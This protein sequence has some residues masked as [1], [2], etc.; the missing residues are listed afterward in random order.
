MNIHK[1]KIVR[2]QVRQ[3][4]SVDLVANNCWIRLHIILSHAPLWYTTCV[5]YQNSNM[6]VIRRSKVKI[7][8]SGRIYRSLKFNRCLDDSVDT[9]ESVE[10][11]V[12]AEVSDAGDDRPCGGFISCT[13][14]SIFAWF[15]LIAPLSVTSMPLCTKQIR[16]QQNTQKDI[17][18]L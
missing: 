12:I 7:E 17:I 9:P 5:R 4:F 2:R 14:S 1:V 8:C 10:L 15:V 13:S 6:S 11:T 18:K 3:K 16:S